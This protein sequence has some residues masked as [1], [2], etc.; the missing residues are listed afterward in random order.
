MCSILRLGIV[1]MIHMVFNFI[2]NDTILYL[3]LFEIRDKH[4]SFCLY[5]SVRCLKKNSYSEVYRCSFLC[6]EFLQVSTCC[7]RL[8][9]D[10]TRLEWLNIS[11]EYTMSTCTLFCLSKCIC[12]I[13]V[14]CTFLQLQQYTQIT[15]RVLQSCMYTPSIEGVRSTYYF[16]SSY[17]ERCSPTS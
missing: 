13:V 1:F 9:E 5:D 14:L 3:F 12:I 17:V 2:Y 11:L 16:Q 8:T 10:F 6:Y 4:V 15:T 7:F